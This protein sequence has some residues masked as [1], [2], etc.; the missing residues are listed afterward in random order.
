MCQ[1]A[2]CKSANLQI[3]DHGTERMQRRFEKFGQ[4][5]MV[6]LLIFNETAALFMMNKIRGTSQLN[7]DILMYSSRREFDVWRVS[8][9][10]RSTNGYRNNN[11]NLLVHGYIAPSKILSRMKSD[12][13]A[14]R[15]EGRR[16]E[17]CSYR[18]WWLQEQNG[19][20]DRMVAVWRLWWWHGRVVAG[21][22]Q[23]S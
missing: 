13:R 17:G 15:N 5:K 16:S 2:N 22:P 7:I 10:Q 14:A 4:R 1:P 12:Q 19:W 18:R 6:R 3:F 20:S 9:C 11:T 23:V 8:S 21:A